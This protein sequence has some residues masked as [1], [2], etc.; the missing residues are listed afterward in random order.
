MAKPLPA[1]PASRYDPSPLIDLTRKDERERLSGSAVKAFF[2]MMARWGVRDEDARALLGGMSNGAF[3]ELKKH[4]DRV[5]EADRLLRVSYLIGIFKALHI[6]HGEALADAWIKL[7]NANR[8]F[9][10]QTPLGFMIGH[11]LPA[12][13]IVRRLL[14]ARRGGA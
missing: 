14:D 12:F 6:L 1:Y 13:Q 7:P 11:G 9:H 5:L 2:A 8:I 3:Y 10:G 4:P